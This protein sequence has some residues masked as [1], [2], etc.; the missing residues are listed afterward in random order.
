MRQLLSQGY[1]GIKFAMIPRMY[2]RLV[3]MAGSLVWNLGHRQTSWMGSIAN[4]IF[5]GN[6]DQTRWKDHNVGSGG[7]GFGGGD[8]DVG[9]GYL[10]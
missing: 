5:N 10:L 4:W 9:G 2:S 6:M 1:T 8:D 7:S 3:T